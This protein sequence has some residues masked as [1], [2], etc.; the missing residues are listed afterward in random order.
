[1]SRRSRASG[2]IL[3]IESPGGTTTG[4]EKLY[5]ELR[6]LAAKKPV[7]AEVGTLAASGGYIAA[8]GA[9]EIVAQGNSLVGSIGV[10]FE[11][12]NV[13]KLLDKV[14]VR[15]RRSNPRR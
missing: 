12:P 4:A 6:R 1:M 10:L 11:F 2:V 13:S 5:D 3:K 7:V 8:L 9:D 15:S 14:G